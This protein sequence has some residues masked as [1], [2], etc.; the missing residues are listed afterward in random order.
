MK[1]NNYYVLE[2]YIKEHQSIVKLFCLPS[3]KHI[4]RIPQ[5]VFNISIYIGKHLLKVIW[6]IDYFNVVFARERD[7][8]KLKNNPLFQL[9]NH[10]KTL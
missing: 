4:F 10:E 8:F 3:C 1:N 7:I 6:T 5:N 2:A 9:P